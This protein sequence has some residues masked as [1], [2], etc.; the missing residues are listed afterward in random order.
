MNRLFRIII[1]CL[2]LSFS[3]RAQLTKSSIPI[4]FVENSQIRQDYG[5]TNIAWGF[6]P[7]D[8]IENP[9]RMDQFIND[10]ELMN[11][12]G[13]SFHARVEFDAG[14]KLFV[15]YTND[16][17]NVQYEDHACLSVDG[18]PAEYPWF[19]FN[20]YKGGSPYW[21][22]SHSPV[23]ED[24]M[25]YQIDKTLEAPID[26]LMI[27]AQTS[28]ALACRDQWV[29]GDFST[30]AMTSFA[31]F[32]N[33]N[34]TPAELD[35]AGISDFNGFSY[36]TFLNDMGIDTD[37]EYKA[38]VLTHLMQE[39]VLPLYEEYRLFN[40]IEINALTERL[41]AYAKSQA[42]HLKIGV[43]SPL[44]D[45]YRSTIQDDITFF[46]QEVPMVLDEWSWEPVLLYKEAELFNTS[47]ALTALPTD[48]ELVNNNQVAEEEAKEWIASA[49][50]NGANFIAPANMWAGGFSWYVPS[51]DFTY[52]YQFISNNTVMFDDYTS[53]ASKVG[54]IHSREAA[55]HYTY[56]INNV[57]S[58]VEANSIPW[59]LIL[60]GDA[61]YESTPTFAELNQYEKV[62]VAEEVYER[63]LMDN[64]D[65]GPTLTQLGS[66]LVIFTEDDDAS[67]IASIQDDLSSSISV[68]SNGTNIADAIAI[69]PRETD[70]EFAPYMVHM[71]NRDFDEGSKSYD[72]KNDV[73]VTIQGNY[74][75]QI[76]VGAVMHQPGQ[77]PVT[78]DVTTSG[79][80]VT[81]SGIQNLDFWGLLELQVPFIITNVDSVQFDQ[82]NI[83]LVAGDQATINATIFPTDA[84]NKSIAW[85]SSNPAVAIVTNGIVTGAGEGTATITAI[86]DDGGH[87]DICNV[88]VSVIDVTSISISPTEAAFVPGRSTQ[89]T[90]SISPANASDKSVTWTSSNSSIATVSADGEVIGV[91]AGT[92]TITATTVDGNFTASA[93]IQVFP[94][95]A[96]LV[97]Q[98]ED[99]TA[100]GGASD[101]FEIYKANGVDGINYNQTGDWGDYIVDITA[102]GAYEVNMYISTPQDGAAVEIFV[103]GVSAITSDVPNNGGWDDFTSFVISEDLN[104]TEGT[105]VL[106]FE[107]A[108]TSNWEWNADRFELTQL[109]GTSPDIID[110]D[111]V[112]LDSSVLNLEPEDTQSLIA[113]IS[114]LN[115]TN[116]NVTWSS[117]NED[118]ATVV[119]GMVTA[120]A[121]GSANITVTTV[122]GDFTST[123][124]VTVS[125]DDIEVTD[126]IMDDSEVSLTE[127]S[128]LLLTA[129]IE[130]ANATDQSV[131]WSSSDESIVSVSNGTISAIAV[132]SATVTVT[133]ND[134]GYTSI[135][136]I[137]VLEIVDG[138]I[139]Q[140]EDFTATG[141]AY[142]GFQTYGVNGVSAIN[143]NQQGDWADY[144][145]N[146]EESGNYQIDI[147]AGT[148]NDDAGITVSVDGAVKITDDIT[149]NGD[150]D[151]FASNVLEGTLALTAGSHTIRIQSANGSLWQWNADYFELTK[152]SDLPTDTISLVIEAENFATTG[153]TAMN[154]D[155]SV[156]FLTYVVGD[157]TAIN[158]N[159]NG[160]WAEY[161]VEIPE[162]G[163][164]AIEYLISTPISGAAVEF[165]LDGTSIR[166]DN[167]PNNGDWDDFAPLK[168]GGTVDLTAGDHTIRLESNGAGTWAWNMDKFIL[169][170]GSIASA[171]I[172]SNNFDSQ[173]DAGLSTLSV[174]PNPSTSYINIAGIADGNYAINLYDL[175]G[176][177]MIQESID[178]NSHYQLNVSALRKGQYFL[179]IQG[180]GTQKNLKLIIQ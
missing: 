151:V 38:A 114:P 41:V 171:K 104:L 78:L 60:A 17:A 29:S 163:A 32:L 13:I 111:G 14:W 146:I 55:R 87:T 25:K 129:T 147:F 16:I 1:L 149:N 109:S 180:N 88:N 128:T 5:I 53:V 43:S 19:A 9:G 99:F 95:G 135:A 179:R 8:N 61:Y 138:L 139:V 69:Y 165:I 49:Y 134:G 44:E 45:P 80:E 50:A 98:A 107:S 108:G 4:T 164:Y 71:V 10:V 63:F 64:P 166:T 169:S 119:N 127:G 7:L 30:H 177:I 34:Y 121:D 3:A 130:P 6:L 70:V 123:A 156:G 110:V 42:P 131:T 162:T 101:G 160:D 161:N 94:R 35:I 39:E 15:D 22:S 37:A 24:F 117:D 54:I 33:A 143:Y 115:A 81:I 86:T 176:A 21:M 72:V 26:V 65:F 2:C 152:V 103:D 74:F 36:L 77:D 175:S 112:S 136:S 124:A 155:N 126:I 168:V 153:G 159:Q 92:V 100:T 178:F 59:D 170:T 58:A 40:N 125:T 89:L 167:V 172:S 23:Y 144:D 158:W 150:W 142:D 91:S 133:S 173:L 145:V 12:E 66:K 82:S 137:T 76:I 18:Q 174:Y 157:K 79:N 20:T 28:S 93:S 62:F 31:A 85:E 148:P 67:T 68:T 106:R 132:G 27:D 140:A 96:P 113:T 90:A 84:T 57:I 118:V 141:G 105:H 75:D 51:I 122:D 154:N 83:A 48:W 102:T 46:Q 11:S 97:I 120:I 56:A 52:I 116:Q 47:L 73:S